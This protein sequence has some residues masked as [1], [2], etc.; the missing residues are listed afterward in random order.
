MMPGPMQGCNAAPEPV[1]EAGEGGGEAQ[2][3]GDIDA[4]DAVEAH[5][6][7]RQVDDQQVPKELAYAPQATNLRCT[8][9]A[10]VVR[11]C[12]FRGLR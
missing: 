12:T 8:P 5:Q 2:V 7:Q 3:G 9:A 1:E 4:H 10:R 6:V 11:G